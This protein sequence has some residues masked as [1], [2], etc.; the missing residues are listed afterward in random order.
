MSYK[1]IKRLAK[2][3]P[4]EMASRN[5]FRITSAGTPMGLVLGTSTFKPLNLSSYATLETYNAKAGDTKKL[6]FALEGGS[7]NA[8]STFQKV[9][10]SH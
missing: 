10:S 5:F 2:F 3:P 9:N 4:K 1:L 6:L 8:L 7:S